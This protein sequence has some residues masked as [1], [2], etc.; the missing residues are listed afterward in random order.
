MTLLSLLFIW[1][2]YTA[3]NVYISPT[4]YTR[5]VSIIVSYLLRQDTFIVNGLSKCLLYRYKMLIIAV[6]VV[7]GVETIRLKFQVIFIVPSA[8]RE[9][10][11]RRCIYSKTKVGLPPMSGVLVNFNNHL[12]PCFDIVFMDNG[13]AECTHFYKNTIFK[14]P[15]T[16][17]SSK[18]NN[19]RP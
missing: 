9:F 7:S 5:N 13:N 17:Q 16:C 15:S 8:Q 6:F 14:K 10:V 11:F 18:V 3:W 12:T 4:D 1:I 2:E 19:T